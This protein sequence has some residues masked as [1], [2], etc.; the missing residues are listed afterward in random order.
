MTTR[1]SL[2]LYPLILSAVPG[3]R[4]Q[5][6]LTTATF[7]EVVES[8]KVTLESPFLQ[9]ELPPL[10]QLFLTGF[11]FQAPHQPHCPLD[12]LKHL[13]VL[14]K[15][16][17]PELDT[18]LKVWSDQCR[19]QGKNELPAPAGHTIPDPGQD[20]IGPLGHLGTL[21]AHVDQYSQIPF[22]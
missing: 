18:A 1:H 8:D 10:P 5:T 20:A 11:V 14:P 2:R 13:N 4:D 19:V 22:H 12:V 3:E 6:Q 17:G 7:Q 16:R 21:L 15:L 9:A